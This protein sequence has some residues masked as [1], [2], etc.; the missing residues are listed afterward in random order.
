MRGCLEEERMALV[1]FKAFIKTLDEYPDDSLIL[2]D[3]NDNK[4]DC[5]DWERVKCDAT[6]GR[7]ME[8][9]LFY[10]RPCYPFP[11]GRSGILNFSL[12][13]AFEEL[14]S[15]DCLSIDL[16]VGFRMK[17]MKKVSE[18]SRSWRG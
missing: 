2:W 15:L 11:Y 7:V 4:S 9:Q 16:L 6:T 12:F 14:V 1:E 10:V 17:V 3:V 8:L 18:V 13:H 5:C